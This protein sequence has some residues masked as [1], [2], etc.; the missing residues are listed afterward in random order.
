MATTLLLL[1]LMPLSLASPPLSSQVPGRF[2]LS[3]DDASVR[4]GDNFEVIVATAHAHA[5]LVCLH[6]ARRGHACT[7][8]R[9]D[10]YS[11]ASA[12]MQVYVTLHWYSY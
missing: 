10:A 9:T 1:M 11:L 5:S 3:T 12:A 8:T 2:E 7:C 6:S 4:R